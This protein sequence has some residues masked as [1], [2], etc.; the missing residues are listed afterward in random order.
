MSD[1]IIEHIEPEKT[2]DEPVVDDIET[3]SN[4]MLETLKGMVQ[5]SE[6]AQYATSGEL[7]DFVDNILDF[8]DNIPASKFA[9]DTYCKQ[10]QEV[11]DR[12]SNSVLS[13]LQEILDKMNAKLSALLAPIQAI[14]QPP[15]SLDDILNW[16]GRVIS[17]FTQFYTLITGLISEIAQLLRTLQKLSQLPAKLSQK[18]AQLGCGFTPPAEEELNE[19]I[20][21]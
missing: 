17:F 12:I 18:M 5:K 3:S 21:E 14:L 13:K 8:V 10:L 1:F 2:H 15:T 19:I 7:S 20:Q 11:A 6:N 9:Q 4:N 16:A